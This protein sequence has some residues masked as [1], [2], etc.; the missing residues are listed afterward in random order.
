MNKKLLSCVAA[1]GICLATTAS[2]RTDSWY[3]S[4]HGSLA[5]ASDLKADEA[6]FEGTKL[7]YKTGF[8]GGLAIGHSFD[9][10]RFE[11]E[12]AYRGF[13][14]KSLVLDGTNPKLV[15][16][17]ALL[18]TPL[19]LEIKDLT[20]GTLHVLSFM[21]NGFYDFTLTDDIDLYVGGGLGMAVV[22]PA[23]KANLHALFKPEIKAAAAVFAY[24]LMLGPVWK[25]DE[26]WSLS[27]GYR[28]MSYTKP[29]FTVIDSG[30][31]LNF[32]SNYIH[33]L[34]FALRYSF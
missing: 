6:G 31:K 19:P 28:F 11:F 29:K 25:I 1:A 27:A 17:A 12:L 24:Q 33:S 26:H 20:T 16:G 7:K 5:S 13:K 2:A 14:N 18:G 9:A 10:F 4:A 30:A 34:D 32:K 22:H 3:V 21:F 23:L 15:T 8:G